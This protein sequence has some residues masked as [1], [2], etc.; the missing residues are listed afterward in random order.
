MF[1]NLPAGDYR[2]VAV[3]DVQQGE[4][5]NPDFLAQLI[6]ASI[7]VVVPDGGKVVQD[8]RIK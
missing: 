8:M 7:K 2:I 4:W 3:T 6:D 1:R 5:L